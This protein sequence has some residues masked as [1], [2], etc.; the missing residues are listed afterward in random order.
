MGELAGRRRDGTMIGMRDG[1]RWKYLGCIPAVAFFVFLSAADLALASGYSRA[2][3]GEGSA[4]GVCIS[5]PATAPE[6][7]HSSPRFRQDRSEIDWGDLRADI[8]RRL[9]LQGIP[10]E[11]AA[12]VIRLRHEISEALYGS[13]TDPRTWSPE[14]EKASS[15]LIAGPDGRASMLLIHGIR[16]DSI[17]RRLRILDGDVVVLIDGEVPVFDP[18]Q[19]WEWFATAWRLAMVLDSGGVVSVTL[20]RAGLPVHME[21]RRKSHG[22]GS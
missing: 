17:L 11:R 8:V 2:F 9:R 14:L 7:D 4:G 21:F 19:S 20:L 13:I 12:L 15:T 5:D 3:I 1:N 22:T 10:P 16:R 18:L 6:S